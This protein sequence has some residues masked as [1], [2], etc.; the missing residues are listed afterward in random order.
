MLHGS[1]GPL[2]ALEAELLHQEPGSPLLPDDPA[3]FPGASVLAGCC[4]STV[5]LIQFFS[6]YQEDA[7]TSQL[8]DVKNHYGRGTLTSFPAR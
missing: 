6:G 7:D 1:P 5:D 4:V 8:F 2:S 3:L